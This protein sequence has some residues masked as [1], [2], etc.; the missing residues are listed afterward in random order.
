MSNEFRLK[1]KEIEIKISPKTP[2]E[3]VINMGERALGTLKKLKESVTLPRPIKVPPT[4]SIKEV[5]ELLNI[6]RNTLRATQKRLDMLFDEVEGKSKTTFSLL[7]YFAIGE[8]LDLFKV[9]PDGKGMFII[10]VASYKGGVGKTTTAVSLAQGLSLKGI[11][12]GLIIDMDGQSSASSLM[13]LSPE[14]ED[15]TNTVMDYIYGDVPSLR[16]VIQESYWPRLDI[17]SGS[18]A[19]MGAEYHFSGCISTYKGEGNYPFWNFLLTGLNELRD[20]Y[21][22]CVID[23]SPSLGYLTQNA[24]HAC[25]GLIS[26][27]PQEALDFASMAQ[28]WGVYT[29][30][31]EFFPEMKK[32]KSFDFVEILVSKSKP[33]NSDIGNELKKWIKDAY[34]AHLCD[35]AIPES[36]I[37]SKTSAA[38]S[39]VIEVSEKDLPKESYRRYKEPLMAFIDHIHLEI[40]KAWSR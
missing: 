3:E 17:I 22:F 39:T 21:A 14:F 10:T 11:G 1:P 29:E 5:C 23:T 9:K 26:P 35:I 37:P 30:L 20:D 27:L 8:D 33:E 34:G 36:V 40:F 31:V 13:G 24:I 7:D 19:L 28:F 6:D 4:F 2:I 25:D 32:D 12:R 15:D 38:Y 18:S 16:N